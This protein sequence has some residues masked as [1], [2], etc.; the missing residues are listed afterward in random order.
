MP[1]REGEVLVY[2]NAQPYFLQ[3]FLIFRK[4][5]ANLA[6]DSNQW[7]VNRHV[8]IVPAQC[9]LQ[10]PFEVIWR[11]MFSILLKVGRVLW[12]YYENLLLGT[13]T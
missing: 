13:R 5:Y 2:V 11:P 4:L 10:E 9:F 1:N 12:I 3:Q 8:Q 7:E 6:F